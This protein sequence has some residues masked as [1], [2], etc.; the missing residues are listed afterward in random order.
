MNDYPLLK[1]YILKIETTLWYI[2]L[3][4]EQA[5][6]FE[7]MRLAS[8][9]QEEVYARIQE[10]IESRIEYKYYLPRKWYEW[11]GLYYKR[12]LYHQSLMLWELD[13]KEI[14]DTI[15][16]TRFKNYKSIFE[17]VEKIKS[18]T[19]NRPWI[20]QN[21]VESI[22]S[23]YNIQWPDD[24]FR[25]YTLEQFQWMT[26]WLIFKSNEYTDEWKIMNDRAIKWEKVVG[27]TTISKIKEF[28]KQY[29]EQQNKLKSN[30]K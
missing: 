7:N 3:K 17:W 24:L 9:T 6:M 19:D 23:W 15:I 25:K 12:C 8:K 20:Y 27:A 16:E 1:E 29:E 13:I 10:F 5:T 28:Q 26:D 18:K 4:Y 14:V 22:C 2:F 11:S 21:T 30:N